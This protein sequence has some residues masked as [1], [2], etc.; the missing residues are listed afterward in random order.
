MRP[1][2]KADSESVSLWFALPKISTYFW[3]KKRGNAAE[4]RKFCS[5]FDK[6]NPFEDSFCT[7][8]PITTVQNQRTQLWNEDSLRLLKIDSFSILYACSKHSVFPAWHK[9]FW[10]TDSSILI[11][12]WTIYR[13]NTTNGMGTQIHYSVFRETRVYTFMQSCT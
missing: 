9:I 1:T 2:A 7:Q 8:F 3:T 6:L 5:Q 12:N 13:Q 11:R 10:H 4:N